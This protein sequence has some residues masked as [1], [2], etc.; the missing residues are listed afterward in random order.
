MKPGRIGR[1]PL[2]PDSPSVRV[3]LSV[4]ARQYDELY[5]KAQRERVSVPELMRRSFMRRKLD[6]SDDDD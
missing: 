6:S 4:P 5:A 1:P 2:D 3:S